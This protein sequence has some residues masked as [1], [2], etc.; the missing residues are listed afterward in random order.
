M[1]VPLSFADA[2]LGAQVKVPTLTEPVTLKVK[3]GTQPGTTEKV[4]GRGIAGTKGSAGDLFVT[5]DVHRADQAQQG[6]ASRG[7]VPRRSARRR[8][9]QGRRAGW[10]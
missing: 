2:A 6:A 9:D 5:F 8:D 7:R 3:A 10:I 1:K 4:Q